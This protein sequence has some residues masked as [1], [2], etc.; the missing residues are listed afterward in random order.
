MALMEAVLA[1]D[2]VPISCRAEALIAYSDRR[3]CHEGP[4]ILWADAAERAFLDLG[5]PDVAPMPE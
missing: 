2:G 4:P 5:H 3:S 1:A